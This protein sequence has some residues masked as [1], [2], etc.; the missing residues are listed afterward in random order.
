M[1]SSVDIKESA[2]VPCKARDRDV[3]VPGEDAELV[4]LGLAVADDDEQRVGDAGLD[5]LLGQVGLVAWTHQ[6]RRKLRE[7]RLCEIWLL[8]MDV[9]TIKIHEPFFTW[10]DKPRAHPSSLQIAVLF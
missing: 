5:L 6:S 1:E 9:H 2:P 8:Q 10:H 7:T 3:Y 4:V